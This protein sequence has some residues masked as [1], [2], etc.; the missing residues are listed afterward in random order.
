MSRSATTNLYFVTKTTQSSKLTNLIFS[1]KHRFAHPQGTCWQL[2]A[3][4]GFF[5]ETIDRA[6]QVHCDAPR[7]R[8]HWQSSS[9]FMVDPPS[10]DDQPSLCYSSRQRYLQFG[11]DSKFSCLKEGSYQS[12]GS[13]TIAGILLGTPEKSSEV[14]RWIFPVHIPQTT[15]PRQNPTASFLGSYYIFYS[16]CS[17]HAELRWMNALHVEIHRFQ[18][19]KLFLKFGFF[20][21][22]LMQTSNEKLLDYL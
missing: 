4:F 10:V 22:F 14:E 17:L 18:S 9:A 15:L 19:S 3:V 20:S 8:T 1:R 13:C 6:Q 16:N 12:R 21:Y 7:T 11:E 2:V 5:D